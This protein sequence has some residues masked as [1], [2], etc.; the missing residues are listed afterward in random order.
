MTFLQTASA[1]AGNL[2]GERDN[3]ADDSPSISKHGSTA[4]AGRCRAAVSHYSPG[5]DDDLSAGG[6]A[7]QGDRKLLSGLACLVPI[8]IVQRPH[9]FCHVTSAGDAFCAQT[10]SSG[11]L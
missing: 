7:A 11:I 10:V 9:V 3:V 1:S 6:S 8:K 5:K 4:A 2:Y